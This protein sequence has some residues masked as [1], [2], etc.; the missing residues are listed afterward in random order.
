MKTP[1]QYHRAFSSYVSLALY[2][3]GKAFDLAKTGP[4]RV[5]LRDENQSPRGDATLF[6]TVGSETKQWP[7]TIDEARCDGREIGYLPGSRL[8]VNSWLG[9]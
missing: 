7:I 6:I 8:V 2:A 9:W 5:V 4:D 1:R 3:Q